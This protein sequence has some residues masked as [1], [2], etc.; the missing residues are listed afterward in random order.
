MLVYLGSL[1]CVPYSIDV[2]TVAIENIRNILAVS[3]NQI[4]YI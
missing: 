4:E 1:S 3:T 2:F